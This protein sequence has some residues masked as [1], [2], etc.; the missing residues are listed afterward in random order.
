VIQ[1]AFFGD[2][3]VRFIRTLDPILIVI[4]FGRQ[5]MR[6]LVVAD[7]TAAVVPRG[8]KPYRLTDFEFALV[9]RTV[10]HAPTASSTA[11]AAP[12][13]SIAGFIETLLPRNWFVKPFSGP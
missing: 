6:D 8:R 4:A 3:L 1:L 5:E 12:P 9:H 10:H 2:P 13:T 7:C 11:F